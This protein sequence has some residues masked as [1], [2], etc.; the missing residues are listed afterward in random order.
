MK[1]SFLLASTLIG[2]GLMHSA[3]HGGEKGRNTLSQGLA[4]PTTAFAQLI[5]LH[6]NGQPVSYQQVQG[7][8][9]GRCFMAQVT[10][11]SCVESELTRDAYG[12]TIV[13][14]QRQ[15]NA[16]PIFPATEPYVA[17]AYYQDPGQA[18]H[19]DN[20]SARKVIDSL[21]EFE[22]KV[23]D[24]QLDP[25]AFSTVS[26]VVSVV[27]SNTFRLLRHSFVQNGQYLIHLQTLLRNYGDLHPKE[28]LAVC[29]YFQ[30]LN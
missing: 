30:K 12:A 28:P 4:E 27:T 15:T 5:E 10:C 24:L 6:K 1:K 17:M 8:Y 21:H 26:P 20:M 9:S 3:A 23:T 16:G 7:V 25:L 29:Y 18:N 2:L 11:F 19:F 14:W 13:I 22:S